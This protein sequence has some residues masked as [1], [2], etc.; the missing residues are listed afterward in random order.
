VGRKGC[1]MGGDADLFAGR[2]SAMSVLGGQNMHS[3][4]Y[5][6]PSCILLEDARYTPPISRQQRKKW[7][8]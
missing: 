3:G 8:V 1:A 2:V 6:A 7:E 4:L 5:P